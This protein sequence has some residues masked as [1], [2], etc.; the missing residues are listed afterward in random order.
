MRALVV[1]DSRALRS[2]MRD[3]LQDIGFEVSTACDGE[4]ALRNL[5]QSGL[6]DVALVDWNMPVMD[7]LAFVQAVRRDSALRKLPLMMVTSEIEMDQM[8]CAMANG[9]D[10]YVMKPFT[11]EDITEK[12]ALIGVL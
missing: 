7:G 4:D 1:D 6:P 3:L 11:K 8:V 12:L 10:E 5:R 2:V 9:A